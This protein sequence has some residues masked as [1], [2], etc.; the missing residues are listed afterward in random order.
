MSTLE[1][2][3][4]LLNRLPES[5]VEIIYS[6]VQFLDAKQRAAA[7]ADEESVDEIMKKIVGAIPDTG[8]SL[9]EYKRERITDRYETFD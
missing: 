3:I 4:Y 5:Q 6:F 1:K 7:S 2:T 8:K 9:E